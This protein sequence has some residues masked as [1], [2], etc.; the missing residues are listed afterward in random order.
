MQ[1][2]VRSPCT[3]VMS[4]VPV[5]IEKRKRRSSRGR[6]FQ[7][8]FHI[9]NQS[10]IWNPRIPI[11]R[12]VEEAMP[13]KRYSKKRWKIALPIARGAEWFISLGHRMSIRGPTVESRINRVITRLSRLHGARAENGGARGCRGAR[14][15]G[16]LVHSD[17]HRVE[18]PSGVGAS[19]CASALHRRYQAGSRVRRCKS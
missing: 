18:G 3:S 15:N 8:T 19:V 7:S 12:R 2:F 9:S 13:S 14:E 11:E 1:F 5:R 17:R 6:Q 16:A 4:S 10:A